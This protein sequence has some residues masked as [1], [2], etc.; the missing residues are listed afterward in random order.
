M[1]P[2]ASTTEVIDCGVVVAVVS[3]A[4]V[5]EVVLLIE[6]ISAGFWP[7]TR[8]VTAATGNGDAL[9]RNV[10]TGR[11]VPAAQLPVRVDAMLRL[12]TRTV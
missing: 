10:C 5:A 4:S 3:D 2:V 6:S 8:S 11:H 12:A 1:D 7:P 9:V